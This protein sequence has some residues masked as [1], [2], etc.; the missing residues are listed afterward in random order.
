MDTVRGCDSESFGPVILSEA[1][2]L[3]FWLRINFVKSLH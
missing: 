3:D 2:G 1:K